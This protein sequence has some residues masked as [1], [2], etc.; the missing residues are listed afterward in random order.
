[1]RVYEGAK[2]VFFRLYI[3]LCWMDMFFLSIIL[4]HTKINITAE[5]PSY[6]L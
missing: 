3:S 5:I 1:M 4:R 2:T 6:G